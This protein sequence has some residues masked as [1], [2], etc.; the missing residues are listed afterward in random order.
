M[1][2]NATTS[3]PT[4]TSG[5]VLTAANLNI[6]NSGIPVFADAAARDAAFDGTGEKTLAEGQFA[7][8]E[9]TNATQVYDGTVWAAVGGATGGYAP[10][11]GIS[12]EFITNTYSWNQNRTAVLNRTQFMPIWLSSA[13]TYDR[14]GCVGGSTFS[15]T[16]TVRLGIYAHDDSTVAPSTLVLDAGTVSVTSASSQFNITISQSLGVGWYWLAFNMQSA[17]STSTFFGVQPTS[18]YAASNAVDA[19]NIINL[20]SRHTW[21]QDSVT[22]AFADAAGL[23]RWNSNITVALRVA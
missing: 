2:A 23:V 1:G 6:T 4:Y 15:G 17:A 3:V 14:I 9:D 18:R 7:F 5:D 11:N 12:G 19:S 8:L 21:Y 16:A 13:K 10:M 22:G 20:N